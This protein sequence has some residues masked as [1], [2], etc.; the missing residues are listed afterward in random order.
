[1]YPKSENEKICHNVNA[2]FDEGAKLGAGYKS[3]KNAI[4]TPQRYNAIAIAKW[5]LLNSS[6][7]N[8]IS[9]PG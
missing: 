5:A 2:L 6:A 3:Q 1:M 8:E 9:Q 4:Y 7:N